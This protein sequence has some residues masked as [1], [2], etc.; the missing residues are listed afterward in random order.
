MVTS[1]HPTDSQHVSD[2]RRLGVEP[3][4]DDVLETFEE[5]SPEE[6]MALEESERRAGRSGSAVRADAQPAADHVD[7][8]AFEGFVTEDVR[9]V[10]P[11]AD[12]P[13][14]PSDLPSMDDLFG[15]S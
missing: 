14:D 11:A 13:E 7:D 6:I 1:R 12:G 9:P 4:V 10:A 15:D 2:V 8:A 5:S 3:A